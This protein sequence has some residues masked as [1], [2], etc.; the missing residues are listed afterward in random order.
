MIGVVDYEAGNIASVSNALTSIGAKFVISSDTN[1]LE[2]CG[3]IILPGVGSAVGA[4]DSLK[5]SGIP[6]FLRSTPVPILG[7]CLGMQLLYASSEEGPTRCL[8][9]LPGKVVR[10][11][12]R[13]CKI[14]HMGWN[15]IQHLK[16]TPLLEGIEEG[17]HFYFAHSF[18]VEVDE[19]AVATTEEGLSFAS[20]VQKDNYTGVQ[21]HPEKSGKS[22]L[23]VLSNFVRTCL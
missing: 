12:S 8:G 3:G 22:G 21:F 5:A 2:T 23:A 9:I 13:A 20:V 4:M 15:A 7:I 11:D 19:S 6:D 10:F 1:V 17:Q 16:P 18:Y 14:P